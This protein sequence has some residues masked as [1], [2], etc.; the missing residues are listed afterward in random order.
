MYD[1]CQVYKRS[2]KAEVDSEE[3]RL[4]PA[5]RSGPVLLLCDGPIVYLPSDSVLTS[6]A[7]SVKAHRRRK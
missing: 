3:M 4:K 1:A 7:V 2:I 5:G 6:F